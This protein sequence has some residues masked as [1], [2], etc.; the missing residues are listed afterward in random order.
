MVNVSFGPHARVLS[1]RR[2]RDELYLKDGVKLS[3]DEESL[4]FS[5]WHVTSWS[6]ESLSACLRYTPG[7][8]GWGRPTALVGA[9]A[10]RGARHSIRVLRAC[11][12]LGF[13]HGGVLAFATA[14]VRHGS[15]SVL[16]AMG[17]EVLA[18]YDD[19]T[20]GGMKLLVFDTALPAPGPRR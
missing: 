13:L 4:D 11:Y 20:R 18:E 1:I 9:W 7:L 8:Y 16:E 10:S 15:S 19:P 6:G 3:S 2:L 14:T 12:E 5:S 17:G